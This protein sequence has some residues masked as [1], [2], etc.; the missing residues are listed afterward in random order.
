MTQSTDDN[1][2]ENPVTARLV[3]KLLELIDSG[4]VQPGQQLLPERE[5]AQKM[6]VSRQSLR[7]SIASLAMIGVLESRHGSGTFVSA[8]ILTCH[9][10]SSRSFAGVASSQ[11]FEARLRIEVALVELAVHRCTQIQIGNL[12]E[13]IVEMFAAL[14]D[15]KKFVAH[16]MRFHRVVARAAGN[17][18]LYAMFETTSASLL[19]DRLPLIQHLHDLRETAA[20]HREIYKAIR[21]RDAFRARL[22]MERHLES[23]YQPA[24]LK[25]VLPAGRIIQIENRVAST[26]ESCG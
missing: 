16:Y 4:A 26:S 12:A 9:S 25:R 13:E 7:A 23:L 8:E 14:E 22:L 24:E 3:V 6:K 5:L 18:I 11:L 2:S 21:C 20:I 10:K 1:D 15:R 17:A 19:G